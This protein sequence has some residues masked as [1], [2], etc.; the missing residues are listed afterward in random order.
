MAPPDVHDGDESYT[1]LLGKYRVPK[2]DRRIE[3][4]GAVDESTAVLGLA[5]VQMRE[6]ERVRL[7]FL[8]NLCF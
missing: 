2:Y 1:G 4:L 7:E 3:A 5:R 8:E 6:L